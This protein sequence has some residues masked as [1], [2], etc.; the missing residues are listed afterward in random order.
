MNKIK[1]RTKMRRRIMNHSVYSHTI[2]WIVMDAGTFWGRGVFVDVPIYNHG[3][4]KGRTV[5][6]SLTGL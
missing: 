3:K 5:G 6:N 2:S 4:R 1:H